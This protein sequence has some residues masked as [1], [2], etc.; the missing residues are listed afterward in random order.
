MGD[1]LADIP[2]KRPIVVLAEFDPKPDGTWPGRDG[3]EKVANRLAQ[4]LDREIRW[5]LM[6]NKSK[7]VREWLLQRQ[8]ESG[9]DD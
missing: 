1:L 8:Q 2:A 9:Y 5:G 6:P 4:K 3:A 7:D